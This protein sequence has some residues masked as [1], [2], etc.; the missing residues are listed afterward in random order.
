MSDFFF[1]LSLSLEI[2][3]LDPHVRYRIYIGDLVNIVLDVFS[4]SVNAIICVVCSNQ[5]PSV[6]A[7]EFC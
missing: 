4:D 5:F 2:M 6:W 3:M 7:G 1:F